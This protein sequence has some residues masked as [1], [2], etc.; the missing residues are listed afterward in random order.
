MRPL[1][2]QLGNVD[3]TNLRT[4]SIIV[5]IICRRETAPGGLDDCQ[6]FFF[7]AGRYLFG[8]LIENRAKFVADY[9]PTYVKA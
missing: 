7:R 4:L 1:N 5:L 2:E 8:V 3:V 9:V 6:R